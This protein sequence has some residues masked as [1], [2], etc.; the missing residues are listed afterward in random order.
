MLTKECNEQRSVVSNLAILMVTSHVLIGCVSVQEQQSSSIVTTEVGRQMQDP[1]EAA[2]IRTAI[3][4][5]YIRDHQLDDA[6][7][8]LER[9]FE[10]DDKYAPAYD[11]MGVLLQQEGSAI[12]LKRAEE[13]YKKAISI[14]PNF[15]QAHNNYGVYLSQVKRHEEALKQFEIAGAMLGYEGRAGAL[16]NLGRTALM[17]NKTEV[18]T[19]AF[20]KALDTNRQSVIARIELIDI[21]LTQKKYQNAQMLYNDL[22]VLMGNNP[23]A[24]VILQGIR[25]AKAYGRSKEQQRL[26]QQLFDFYPVSDEAK[27]MKTWLSNPGV[28]WN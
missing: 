5:Q 27:K 24:R 14:D 22:T 28:A 8:Q 11:M 3:A 4:G 9:A 15:A 17:L 2:R 26:T 12:N 23:D 10:S 6:K 25:L 16:E 20:I 19:Q 13:Y 18:A 21:F 1:Q 7:R